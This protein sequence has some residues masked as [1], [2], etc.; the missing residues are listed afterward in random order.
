ME[1]GRPL[2]KCEVESVR[3]A[4]YKLA[5]GGIIFFHL[6]RLRFL[7]IQAPEEQKPELI[8]LAETYTQFARTMAEIGAGIRDPVD[9]AQLS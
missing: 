8:Q 4:A 6:Y 2:L 5:V 7:I 3:T 9:A 1:T